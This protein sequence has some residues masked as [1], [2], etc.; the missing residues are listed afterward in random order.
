MP[1]ELLLKLF[2][3][4]CWTLAYLLI[5][6]RAYLDKVPGMPFPATCLNTSWEGMMLFEHE[7][8][9][10]GWITVFIWFALDLVI[11]AQYFLYA[12]P[13]NV[14]RLADAMFWP[15]TLAIVAVGIGTPLVLN[16]AFDN[17][18][19]LIAAYFQ[20][21]LMSILFCGMLLS[22]DSIRGQS[23]Y[24]ALAKMFGTSV[25]ILYGEPSTAFLMWCWVLVMVFDLAYV[26]LLCKVAQRDGIR[27]L[28]RL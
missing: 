10:I 12:R 28:R 24:I 14:T 18:S 1:T 13:S 3:W 23:V 25:A 20:N 22:R 8:G 9:G 16:H 5:I 27:V 7:F 4:S 6:R 11:V 21:A 19:G 2:L 26:W 15:S 17:P